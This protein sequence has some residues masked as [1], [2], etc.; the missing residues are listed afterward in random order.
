M[1]SQSV[2]CL[3]VPRVMGEVK[4]HDRAHLFKLNDLTEAQLKAH[5]HINYL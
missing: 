5:T 2:R 1:E 4:G 3:W